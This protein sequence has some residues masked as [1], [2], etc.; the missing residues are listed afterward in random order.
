[1]AKPAATVTIQLKDINGYTT[2]RTY[3]ARAAAITD[4]QAEALADDLQALTQLE[5]TDV[6]VS[7]RAS[8]FTP[9][10]A[11]ANSSIA[12][13]ASLTAPSKTV[14]GADAGPYTFNLPAVKQAFKSGKNLVA[15]DAAV[16]AFLAQFDNADGAA[17]S[18]G[19]FYISDGEEISEVGVEAGEAFGK[20]NK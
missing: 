2:S 5:V 10:A 9:I 4:V 7:R 16:L 17:A 15:T 18:D 13:T 12:E 11:E 20:I 14:A 19:L 6:I 8:G 1:M 3:A